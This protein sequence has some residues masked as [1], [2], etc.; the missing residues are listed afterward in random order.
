MGD[1]LELDPI[2]MNGWIAIFQFFFSI[3]LAV[4]AGY[5][6]SPPIGP[7]ELPRNIYHGLLCYFGR[8][9]IDTGCHP[10][11]MCSFHAALFVNMSLLMNCCYNLLMMYTLKYGSASLLYVALTVMVPIGN[12]AFALPFMPQR[13]TVRV[14]D[15]LGLGV[16]MS[17]LVLYRF[18]DRQKDSH[19]MELTESR[20]EESSRASLLR[21][22][23][24]TGEVGDV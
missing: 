10:D 23:L 1:D 15:L 9:S 13:A 12:F 21:E 6:S 17:G 22:P 7:M 16:I 20:E 14:S 18:A 3:L 2:F 11:N 4:P 24:V 19:I 5:A 8:G